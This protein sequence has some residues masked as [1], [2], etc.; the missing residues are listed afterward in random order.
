MYARG[1]KSLKIQQKMQHSLTFSQ[2]NLHNNKLLRR[3]PKGREEERMGALDRGREGSNGGKQQ[4]NCIKTRA[5]HINMHR[6]NG[7]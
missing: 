3:K 1:K 2:S 7:N 6:T 5:M 4:S